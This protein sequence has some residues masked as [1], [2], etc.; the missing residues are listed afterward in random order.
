MKSVLVAVIFLVVFSGA[1]FSIDCAIKTYNKACSLCSFDEKGKIDESCRR[2]YESI[3][4][5]CFSSSY[6]TMSA[7]YAAGQCPAV[8]SCTSKLKS[9]VA[10]ASTGN[11]KNDCYEESVKAC[12][13]T[14]DRCM[15]KAAV[16]CGEM[17]STACPGAPNIFI[18]LLV[19][20]GF[21][22]K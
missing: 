9:C 21:L 16:E 12:Y 19:G 6:P 10:E 22:Y 4:A 17:E 20:L 3:G 11:D 18:L 14:A 8:D 13:I 7:K 2:E 15:E 5:V 1:A